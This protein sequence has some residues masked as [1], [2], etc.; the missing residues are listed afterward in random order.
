MGPTATAIIGAI[1]TAASLA[2]TIV[3]GIGSAKAGKAAQAAANMEADQYDRAAKETLA[4]GQRDMFEQDRQEGLLQGQATVSAAGQGTSGD[5]NARLKAEVTRLSNYREKLA[6]YGATER[7]K[8][9]REQAK[10]TRLTGKA[11]RQAGRMAAFGTILGGAGNAA[12]SFYN[13]FG[14]DIMPPTEPAGITV[15]PMNFSGGMINSGGF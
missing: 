12:N 5:T 3:S 4:A 11:S 15:P 14:S 1:G 8:G 2:G 6:L 9:L 13:M 7:G 10:I